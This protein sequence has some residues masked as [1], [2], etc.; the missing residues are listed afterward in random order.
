MSR[1]L[2]CLVV[3]VCGLGSSPALADDAYFDLPLEALQVTDGGFPEVDNT[4]ASNLNWRVRNLVQAYARLDGEGEAYVTVSRGN[5]GTRIEGSRLRIRAPE[6]KDVT[7][8]VFWPTQNRNELVPVRFKVKAAARGDYRRQFHEARMGYFTNLVNRDIPGAAWFRRQANDSRRVLGVTSDNRNRRN[9][10]FFGGRGSSMADTYALVSGGRA[11]SE[12]LQL[13]RILPATGDQLETISIDEIE[14]ITV[15]EFNWDN[16]IKGL[17]PAGDVLAANIPD[18]QHVLFFPSFQAL[19]DLADNADEQSAPILNLA[20]PRAENARTRERYEQQLGLSLNTATRLIGPRLINS[21]AVTGSDPYLRTGSDVAVLFE[22][23]EANSLRKMIESQVAA[24]S[25]KVDGVAK[26]SGT[27]AGVDF[28]MFKTDNRRVCSYVTSIGKAVVVT[29]SLK[30][31][32]RLAEVQSGKRGSIAQLDEYTFFR[33]RYPLGDADETALLIISDKTIRRWCGPKWRIATSRRTRA[34]AVLTDVQA[35]NL[36]SIVKQK[37]TAGPVYGETVARAAGQVEL[38][39]GGV[40]SDDFGTIEFQ[41][42]IVELDIDRVTKQ[43]ADLYRGWRNGYQR[44]WSNFFDP[45]AVRFHAS[46]KRIA[47]DMTVMPLI[48]GSQYREFIDITSGARIRPDAGDP[49]AEALLHW[50]MAVNRKS[51]VVQ[52]NTNILRELTG[53]NLRV[54]PL[55]WVGETVAA[56]VEDD[57]VWKEIAEAEDLE[58]ILQEKLSEL[59]VAVYVEVSSGSKLILFLAGIRAFIE[60]TAPGMTVWETG[61]HEG[62][63]YVSI[64]PTAQARNMEEELENLAIHYVATGDALVISLHEGVI[65]RAIERLAARR[66]AKKENKPLPR[67]GPAWLGDNLCLQVDK[68]VIDFFQVM[69]RED[70]QARM[71]ELAWGNLPVLNEW[72]RMFPDRDPIA[73]HQTV[74]HSKLVCPGGGKYVWNEEYQTM[75]SDVYGHPGEPKSGPEFPESIRRISRGNFGITFEPDGLRARV[76]IEK[77]K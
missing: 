35:A 42:P 45:I 64:R 55:S 71:Q 52:Q 18:D 56:Y 16:M 29:N 17:S 6:G 21:V 2:T 26:S 49:H 3:V 19:V 67:T 48:T 57:P 41:T 70:Y 14:G 58:E 60:Q 32:E 76:D 63:A 1:V 8:T 59:P 72:K 36:P 15:R 74:W 31:L 13:D 61:E 24:S 37:I 9:R 77:S 43:E 65:K 38:S 27:I 11:L 22:A 69:F 4:Q 44:A 7:G 5:V 62:Q 30:Q 68:R 25:G 73:V 10:R 12:N 75:E 53:N 54:D 50:A 20:E 66:E 39:N 34:M 46:K 51:R 47:A 40:R 28:T 33:D 23:K